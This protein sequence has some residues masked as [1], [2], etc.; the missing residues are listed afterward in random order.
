MTTVDRLLMG[1]EPW[2]IFFILWVLAGLVMAT[3]RLFR[4][5]DLF[6]DEDVPILCWFGVY[7]AYIKAPYIDLFFALLN[8]IDGHKEE[9][10]RYSTQV[11]E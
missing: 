7:I 11:A 2:H 9:K 6:S 10:V 3:I 4:A 1:L 5:P 8:R